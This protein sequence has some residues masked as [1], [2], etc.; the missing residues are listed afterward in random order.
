M[1]QQHKIYGA[2]YD[3]DND[4]AVTSNDQ[5]FREV[6]SVNIKNTVQKRRDKSVG[7]F[8]LRLHDHS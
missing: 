8:M 3:S 2:N 6:E 4:E 1:L 5:Y 7:G